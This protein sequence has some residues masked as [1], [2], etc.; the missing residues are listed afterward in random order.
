MG[1][2]V[3]R[4]GIAMRL[5][6]VIEETW[7]FFQEVYDNLCNNF[8][9]SLY[10]RRE[11]RLPF[12]YERLNRNL[13]HRDLTKFMRNQDVVFFEWASEL[14]MI[15]TH[16]PKT[17]AI[18]TR[19]HRYELYKWA[20]LINWDVVDKVILVSQAKQKEFLDRFPDQHDKTVVIPV[21][22]SLDK[23]KLVE[24]EFQGDIGILGHLTPRKRVYDL[25]LTFFDLLKRKDDF[26]LH[27]GGNNHPVYEDYYESLH[28]LV[29]DL[30]IEDKVSFYGFV[31][32]PWN[33]YSKID[34]FISNSYSEGL[35][36]AP[37]EAIASG[38]YPL[39]HRWRGAG[40]LVPEENLYFT[41]Q[42]LISKILQ[43]SEMSDKGKKLVR[44]NTWTIA[45][46]KFDIE[47]TKV[48]I[49]AVLE[50]AGYGSKT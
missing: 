32:E 6:V 36:V 1:Q 5:G 43:Y 31:A 44:Q 14:L 22:V 24:K 12:F 50:E 18:V 17:C 33:W 4:L 21:G 8:Q 41:N 19:L 9:V 30:G 39:V 49:Q 2:D 37:M 28:S 34:I 45:C 11:V 40:E 29:K 47:K 16:L 35:Q 3:Y 38:C 15:A 13:L 7:D 23:Y 46:E 20:N 48:R 27:I 42:D 25:I 26:H 10:Q